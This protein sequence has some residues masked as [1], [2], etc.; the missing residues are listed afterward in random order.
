MFARFTAL[1][2]TLCVGLPMCWCCIGMERTQEPQASCCT[3]KEHGESKEQP[4]T[5][6][7]HNCPCAKHANK[8]DI[9]SS[10]VKAPSTKMNLLAELRWQTAFVEIASLN[11]IERSVA[12]HDHGP[13]QPAAPVYVRLCALLI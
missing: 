11:H 3:Q 4:Q 6:Q 7:D 10:A 8:R 1:I 2:L 5:P 9:A 13:P 12:R